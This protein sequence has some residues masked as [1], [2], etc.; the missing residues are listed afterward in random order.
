MI[1]KETIKRR[2][3]QD[4]KT[5]RVDVAGGEG[6][7][8]VLVISDAF[9]GLSMLKQHQLVYQTVKDLIQSGELHAL[10]IKSYTSKQWDGAN[11]K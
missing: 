7:Y 8:E 6:K 5:S 11:K 9:E 4:I 2:I 1:D 3:E 10:S